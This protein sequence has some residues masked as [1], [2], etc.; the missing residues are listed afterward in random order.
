LIW[1]NNSKDKFIVRTIEGIELPSPPSFTTED[2]AIRHLQNT[3]QLLD[4]SAMLDQSGQISPDEKKRWLL[5]DAELLMPLFSKGRLCGVFSLGIKG[6]DDPYYKEDLDLLS[7][8]GDQVNISLENAILT[9]ELREQ[10]RLKKELE[11]ARR[12]QISSLPQKD[13][14]VAGLDISG[15]SIPA[16]EV[17][18]DYYDYLSFSDDRFGV[19]IGDVSGKGTSAALYMSQLKGV[20]QTA[21]R[22][23]RSLKELMIEVNAITFDSI[24]LQSYITLLCGAFDVKDRKLHL[25]KAG[26]LPLIH[27]SASDRSFR[28]L[29]PRGLGIGLEQGIIFQ[30]ELEEA[31]IAFAPGDVFLFYTDGIVDARNRDGEEFEASALLKVIQENGWDTAC[32]LRE[33]IISQVRQFTAG[34]SQTDDMTLVV[35]KVGG[36]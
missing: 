7:G 14:Q 17:G 18:G 15:V 25:V 11:V 2:K 24:E 23:H 1:Q 19:V 5:V 28:E 20:L 35:V 26:H 10:D 29:A 27:Y 21:S 4:L 6:E 33:K 36:E 34:A 22:H 30:A 16:L 8:L 9:E 13:P 3:K 32:D 31:Q 12:I